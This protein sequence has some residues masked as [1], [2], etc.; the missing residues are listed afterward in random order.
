LKNWAIFYGGPQI[1]PSIIKRLEGLS[2][3]YTHQYMIRTFD[4][5]CQ[6]STKAL[7]RR[8]QLV[9]LH[10]FRFAGPN[11]CQ[12]CQNWLRVGLGLKTKEGEGI[13]DL[14]LNVTIQDETT[15]YWL[16]ANYGWG[17]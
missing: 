10:T 9:G 12:I 14:V 7:R 13:V 11:I 8:G 6:L 2:W 5:Q 15:S 17:F 16:Y 3:L 1:S 4:Q